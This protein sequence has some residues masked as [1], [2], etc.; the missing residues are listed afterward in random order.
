MFCVALV[1]EFDIHMFSS[2]PRVI[3]LPFVIYF[4]LIGSFKSMVCVKSTYLQVVAR[5]R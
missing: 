1:K 2:G 5:R 3:N 4:G